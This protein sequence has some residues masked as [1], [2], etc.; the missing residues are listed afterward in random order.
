MRYPKYI[1]VNIKLTNLEIAT[2]SATY[3]LKLKTSLILTKSTVNIV[4]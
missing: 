3:D 4:H 1:A 2:V